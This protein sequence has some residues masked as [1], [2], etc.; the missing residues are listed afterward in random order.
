M[1][2]TIQMIENVIE[3]E[4]TK[5]GIDPNSFQIDVP[6]AIVTSPM[7]HGYNHKATC[8]CGHEFSMFTQLSGKTNAGLQQI[9]AALP[10][11]LRTHLRSTLAQEIYKLHAPEN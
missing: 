8:L 2:P 7:V 6:S 3:L 5:H 1:R 9:G 11:L 4:A 10:D